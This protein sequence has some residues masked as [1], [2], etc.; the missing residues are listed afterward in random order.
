MRNGRRERPEQDRKDP[1]PAEEMAKTPERITVK[2]LPWNIYFYLRNEILLS[3]TFQ[4]FLPSI[5]CGN[6]YRTK[7]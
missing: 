7:V 4:H 2:C 5:V 1:T 6:L 3:S